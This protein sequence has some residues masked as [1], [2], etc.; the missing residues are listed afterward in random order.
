MPRRSSRSAA[1]DAYAQG[2][3]S[4]AVLQP[5]PREVV[6]LPGDR[7]MFP[8]DV[9]R[10]V[11]GNNVSRV[12]VKRNVAPERKIRLGHTTV[13]WYESDVRSWIRS[14]QNGGGHDQDRS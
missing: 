8:E 7:L 14:R 5:Q 13:A 3:A 4:E 10:E 12:W 2:T 9:R 1:V 11:F 6:A